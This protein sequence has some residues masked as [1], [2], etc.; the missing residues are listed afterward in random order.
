[1]A[2]RKKKCCAA[3]PQTL[4][5][6]FSEVAKIALEPPD[7]LTVRPPFVVGDVVY[8][9]SGSPPLTVNVVDSKQKLCSVFWFA[10]ASGCGAATL[11]WNTLTKTPTSIEPA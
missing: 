11:A 5:V 7:A 8:L 9:K 2:E 3:K 6:T 10:S 4:A 1:M